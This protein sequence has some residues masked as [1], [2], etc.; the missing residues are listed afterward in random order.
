MF[1]SPVCRPVRGVRLDRGGGRDLLQPGGALLRRRPPQ[2][3]CAGGAEHNRNVFTMCYY[4][5]STIQHANTL[6]LILS[7]CCLR[8]VNKHRKLAND[9]LLPA[10]K[11][12]PAVNSPKNMLIPYETLSRSFANSPLPNTYT[13][14]RGHVHMYYT[15]HG[16]VQVQ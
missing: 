9:A 12:V 14:T 4:K 13:W 6:V 8:K 10:P 2:G 11:W 15:N 7:L 16:S 3:L 5:T 1:A